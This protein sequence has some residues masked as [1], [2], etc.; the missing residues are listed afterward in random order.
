MNPETAQQWFNN[1]SQLTRKKIYVSIVNEI[2]QQTKFLPQNSSLPQRLWHIINQ[3]QTIPQCKTCKADVSWDRR[4]KKYKTFCGNPKCPNIDLD[5]ITN[6]IQKTDYTSAT[7]KRKN[8][9]L[10]RYGHSNFLASD[11]GKQQIQISKENRHGNDFRLHEKTQREKTCLEKYGVKN[12]FEK[13]EFQLKAVQTMLQKYGVTNFN[14]SKKPK[15]VLNTLNNPIWLY[16]QHISNKKTLTEISNDLNVHVTTISRAFQRFNLDVIKF[17]VSQG[18]KDISVFLH[19]NQILHET[20]IKNIIPPHELDI[21]IPDYNLAIEYCG[22]YWH[23]EQKNRD[24]LYHQKKL[25]ACYKKGIQLI[26]IF[27]DEWKL[28]NTQVKQKLLSLLHIDNRKKIHARQTHITSQI[29]TTEKNVFFDQNH[30]QGTGPGSIT[31]G[32]TYEDEI[33]AMMTFIDQKKHNYVLSRYATSNRVIGGFS[34][35]LSRFMNDHEWSTIISF[36][37]L[38]WSNGN[39]YDATGW[40][41][42]KIIP[43]DYYYSPDGRTRYHKFNYRRKNLPKLLKTFDPSKSEREN[44]DAN[45]ILRIWD[46]GKKRYVLTNPT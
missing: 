42:D 1:T 35:L 39:L 33:V 15:Y 46:C 34:R 6:K 41:L 24:R 2:K 28:R 27:E 4:Y 36:A 29:T 31:Y 5:I 45:N 22:L 21:F 30:I 25:K 20:N 19:Q 14:R 18:E 37:D 26:T 32:L 17:P 23:S 8:T 16:N 9:N 43:P 12:V 40:V 13:E 7:L 10:A 38:R 44:C 3:T 11:I